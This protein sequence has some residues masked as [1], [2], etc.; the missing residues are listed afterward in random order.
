MKTSQKDEWKM[1]WMDGWMDGW[2]RTVPLE[3][4]RLS[5][6]L[7]FFLSSNSFFVLDSKSESAVKA[8]FYVS[9]HGWTTASGKMKFSDMTMLLESWCSSWSVYRMLIAKV[10]GF[11]I[12][13]EYEDH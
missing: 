13:Y 9:V 7:S 6:F 12:G 8:V 2:P 3:V 5:L 4:P 10:L 11:R 1:Q